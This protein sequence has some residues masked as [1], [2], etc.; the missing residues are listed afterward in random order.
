[1]TVEISEPEDLDFSTL[2]GSPRSQRDSET[3][4][5]LTK[6]TLIYSNLVFKR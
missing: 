2:S 3:R 6:P 4:S 5:G 1:M